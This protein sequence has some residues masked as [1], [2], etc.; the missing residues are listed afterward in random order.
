MAG[1]KIGRWAVIRQDGNYP[2][3]G[4]LWLCRCDCGVLSRVGGA[5]L[6]SRKSTSCGCVKSAEIGDRSRSHG[7]TGT[8]LY[9]I[10]QNMHRRCGNLKNKNY[11]GRGIAVCPEWREYP[12]FGAW[13]RSSGYSDSLTIERIDVNAGYGPQN[14]TWANAATQA[15]NRR[16]VAKRWDGKLWWHVAQ[17]NGLT[18][19]AYR[20]RLH[21]GWSIEDAATVPLRGR[22]PSR[23]S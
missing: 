16:F 18:S 23:N 11:G 3:G 6:R 10:W 7:E 5:D 19:G 21:Q 22:N 2:R 20:S 1:L 15:A 9:I 17:E 4:A 14:C 8:R 13:A 12:P